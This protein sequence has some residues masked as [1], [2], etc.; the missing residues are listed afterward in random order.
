MEAQFSQQSV[1][2]DTKLVGVFGYPVEHSRSP[3]MHNAAFAALDLP[4]LYVPF[5]VTPDR[6]ETALRSLVALGIVGVNLTIPHKEA[7]LQIVDRATEVAQ[8]VGAVNTV[9]CVDGELIGDCT[10]GY[11]FYQPLRELGVEIAEKRAVVIGAGGAARSVVFRL[12]HEGAKI[13][14]VNR[15]LSRA[16][17]L[18]EEVGRKVRTLKNPVQIREFGDVEGLSRDISESI[19]LVNTTQVGMYPYD[20]EIVSVPLSSFHPDLLVYDLIYNPLETRLLREARERRCQTLSG[21]KM[22]VYQG[23]KAFERWTGQFPPPSVI[24]KMENAV[25][26]GL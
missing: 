24:E 22:L 23:A 9:H 17:A 10:D 25:L 14:L 7:A 11:G 21:V 6:L 3:A 26:A 8:E 13:T 5:A 16:E 2:G 4:Y 1:R 12:A 19:L 18:A 15:T 20:G